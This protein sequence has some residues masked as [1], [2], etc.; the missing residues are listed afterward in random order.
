VLARPHVVLHQNDARY[1]RRAL[2]N[3]W[4]D[5]QRAR[6]ARPA[7]AGGETLERVAAGSGDP[8]GLALDIRVAFDAMCALTPKL[9]AAIAAVD[10]LGL[11]YREAART[12]GIR[13]GTLQSRLARAREQVSTALLAGGP[14]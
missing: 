3:T 11:S 1:L 2:R 7:G 6:A 5:T 12:L 10:V 4:I 8:S 9:R 13:L 14:A